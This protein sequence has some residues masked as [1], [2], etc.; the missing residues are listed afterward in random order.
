LP[1]LY[2]VIL[3]GGAGTRLWPASRLARPKQLLPLTSAHSLL[4]ETLLRAAALQDGELTVSAPLLICNQAHQAM[5]RE[6]CQAI[7]QEPLAVYL[8]PLGRNTAP[9]I[10]LAALHLCDAAEALMLVLPAD[11]VIRD[12]AAFQHAVRRAAHAALAGKL[13]TFG[14]T[15]TQAETGYGYIKAGAPL[16][17]QEGVFQ[18]AEFVEKPDQ[19]TA[20]NYLDSGEYVWNSGMFLFQPALYLEQLRHYRPAIFSAVSQAWAERSVDQAGIHPEARSF[21][22]CPSESI[23]YA[24]MQE[25]SAAAVVRA[26]L[27][28]SD[29]GS[30]DALWR[31]ADKDAQD[32]VLRGDVFT[33]NT[34][35][36]LIRAES[37]Y[38]AVLGLDDVVVVETADAVLVMHKSQAQALKQAITQDGA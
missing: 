8:E 16:D 5:I 1:T 33:A 3:C 19:N 35:N 31:I 14:I 10:A 38:V 29:V 27:G 26:E 11:H 15:P 20:Q 2:P 28:W 18:I 30:W 25:T 13:V 34:H 23:D 37:R 24:V 9:A 12:Q 7:G 32:N 17:A 36:S 21:Q 22:A 4:Q 6:Q